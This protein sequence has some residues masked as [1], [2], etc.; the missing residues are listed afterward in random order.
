MKNIKTFHKKTCIESI[1]L[2]IPSKCFVINLLIDIEKLKLYNELTS[3]V[4]YDSMTQQLQMH[5][6][7]SKP[8]EIV[9]FIVLFIE[10]ALI[11]LFILYS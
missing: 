8:L 2:S 5:I 4:M 1:V 9:S 7:K 11:Y 3:V 10:I 6:T